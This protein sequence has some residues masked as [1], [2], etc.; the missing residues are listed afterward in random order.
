[1]CGLLC[2]KADIAK[3]PLNTIK[4]N[5]KHHVNYLST[6][7][8]MDIEQERKVTA[9]QKYFLLIVTVFLIVTAPKFWITSPDSGYYVGTA[10]S[11]IT[12][13]Q[14]YFNGMPNILYYP[15]IAAI[16][17]LPMSI[18]GEN[19]WV[20]HIY[21]ALISL[22]AVWLSRNYFS[23][24]DYGLPGVAVPI[25]LLLCSGYLFLIYSILSD[26]IFLTFS[27][28]CLVLWRNYVKNQQNKYLIW[29]V[30]LVALCPLIRFQGVFL[31]A[32]LSCSLLLRVFNVGKSDRKQA[33]Y[34]ACIA[35]FII[36]L[37]FA[38]WTLR[39]YFSHSSDAFTM[40]NSFF[41]GLKGL[42]LY[43]RGLAG[44]IDSSW[45]DA[46]WKFAVYRCIF[47]FG[48]LAEFWVG[49]LSTEAKT[50]FTLIL[51]PFILMGIKSW[52]KR[53]T[54]LELFYIVISVLFILK[55]LLFTKHLHV[56]PRYWVPLLPFVILT[57]AYG[58]QN[59]INSSQIFKL[60]KFMQGAGGLVIIAIVTFSSPN[61]IKH[62]SDNER[63]ENVADSMENLQNFSLKNIP[64]ASRIAT[65][66]W[67]VLPHIMRRQ[68]FP[69]LNDPDHQ[70]TI[71][72]ILKYQIEYLVIHDS[73]PRT[74]VPSKSMVE[75]YSGVFSLIFE[76]HMG[77][78]FAQSQIYKINLD[79]IN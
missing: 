11:L 56:V 36:F 66:D 61:L 16:L 65:M 28:F 19:F 47:F 44:N 75:D 77:V 43:A 79:K 59:I 33:F 5:L 42:N 30:I 37:P 64:E 78:E 50:V 21:F 20:F 25:F 10:E 45:I 53:A 58:F 74:S 23:Y 27:L 12:S 70:Q 7:F 63:Y 22:S 62:I 72:R 38:A 18:V 32:A 15:G 24:K 73:F 4:K 31:C 3:H 35:T 14:Y 29:C 69:V 9:A 41:F 6:E 46:D 52:A 34:L 39:N 55:D 8:I 76:T 17:A 48:G 13:F 26:A 67:G 1:M 71:Q 51:M 68:S 60:K 57:I 54:S 2:F 40:S 49:S